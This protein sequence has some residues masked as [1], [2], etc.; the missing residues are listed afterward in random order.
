MYFTLPT[1]TLVPK[2]ARP[3]DQNMPPAFLRLLQK[4]T[5]NSL[6]AAAACIRKTLVRTTLQFEAPLH[7]ELC[8]A[9]TSCE[10]LRET[11]E[12]QTLNPEPRDEGINNRHSPTAT[13]TNTYTH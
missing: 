2:W 9:Q 5:C 11:T 6:R 13:K 12:P 1:F 4:R 8:G 7:A 3:E 10:P